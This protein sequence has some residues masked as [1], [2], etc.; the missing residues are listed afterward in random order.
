MSKKK[1]PLPVAEK[2]EAE[3]AFIIET[4]ENCAA[5]PDAIKSFI[6][7]CIE[8]AL[9]F[10]DVLQRKNISMKRLKFMLFGKSYKSTE[11]TNSENPLD[12]TLIED[13]GNET[14]NT[15]ATQS[16]VDF[17]PATM[18]TMN[19]GD[20]EA[21][22]KNSFASGTKTVQ[23]INAPASGHGRMAHTAYKDYVEI[24]LN[25]EDLKPGDPCPLELIVTH[26][27]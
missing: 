12:S 14:A 9:W 20:I 4:I 7:I 27:Y 16:V 18:T 3:L 26:K 17:T 11:K 13:K 22:V 23:K 1:Q 19:T 21:I 15:D 5:L 24:T 6:I 8:N 2:T 10:P 25:I